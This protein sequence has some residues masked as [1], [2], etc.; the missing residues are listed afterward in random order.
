MKIVQ[1]AEKTVI[2]FLKGMLGNQ[3][4]FRIVAVY[5]LIIFL[6]FLMINNHSLW[7]DEAATAFYASQNNLNNLVVKISSALSSEAQMPG[8]LFAMWG[9]EKILGHGEYLLRTTNIF[10]IY[11]FLYA[12]INSDYSKFVKMFVMVFVMVHPFIWYNMNEARSTIAMFSL[13]GTLLIIVKGNIIS[14]KK[15]YL[16]IFLLL[17]GLSLNMLFLFFVPGIILYVYIIGRDK[18]STIKL[19]LK[20]WSAQIILALPLFAVIAVYYY[21]TLKSGS[22]GMKQ[23]PSL[24]NLAFVFYEFLGMLG[25]GPPRNTLRN[26]GTEINY[27]Q[28]ILVVSFS[29]LVISF[30]IIALFFLA[31]RKIIKKYIFHPLFVSA[32]FISVLF[33]VFSFLFSFRFLGRHLAFVL[34]FLIFYIS[35]LSEELTSLAT[36]NKMIF[37]FSMS[38]IFLSFSSIQLRFNPSYQKDDYK[39]T[40]NHV[41]NNYE[42]SKT[43]YFVGDMKTAAYYGL[44]FE[45]FEKPKNWISIRKAKLIIQ[46]TLNQDLY[47]GKAIVIYSKKHDLFDIGLEKELLL[48]SHKFIPILE[49]KDFIIYE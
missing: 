3:M 27:L 2:V 11:L 13:A 8:Y 17:V 18:Y 5:L 24:G 36:K 47:P 14:N 48:K 1:T 34:P 25:L 44:D 33:F 10:F 4:K 29:L 12:L 43:V 21:Y 31:N 45:N 26:L 42:M 7:I 28:F 46:G 41:L 30:S 38:I 23:L 49:N 39:N 32:M 19:L 9:F 35:E 37:F 22:G 15:K 16:T 6:P 20:N 40:I